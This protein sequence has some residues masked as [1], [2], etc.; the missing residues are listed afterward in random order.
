M[1]LLPDGQNENVMNPFLKQIVL[2]HFEFRVHKLL[3]KPPISP[4]SLVG[5]RL[6]ESHLFGRFEN[7]SCRGIGIIPLVECDAFLIAAVNQPTFTPSYSSEP[8][9]QLKN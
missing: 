4:G 5:R 2:L 9:T 8:P 1:P 6:V 7:A 3:L